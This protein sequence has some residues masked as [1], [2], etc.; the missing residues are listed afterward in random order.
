MRKS[1]VVAFGVTAMAL[2]GCL[3]TPTERALAG[4]ATGAVIAGSTGGNA[5]V[6]AIVGGAAGA[7]SCGVPGLPPCS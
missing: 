2:S 4:A 6:G 5:V 3:N 7:V 1:L